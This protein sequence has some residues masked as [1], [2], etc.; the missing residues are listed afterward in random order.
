[1]QTA[2]SHQAKLHISNKSILLVLSVLTVYYL[3][4]ARTDMCILVKN[5]EFIVAARHP[6]PPFQREYRKVEITV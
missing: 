3:L 5:T 6:P 4:K 1:M 2:D